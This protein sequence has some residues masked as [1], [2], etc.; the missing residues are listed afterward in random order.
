MDE[1][2]NQ[3]TNKFKEY[4]NVINGNKTDSTINKPLDSKD[5]LDFIQKNKNGTL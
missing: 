3:D 4:V 5:L 2:I 1:N